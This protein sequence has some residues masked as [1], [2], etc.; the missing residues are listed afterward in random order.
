MSGVCVSDV[1]MSY[2]PLVSKQQVGLKFQVLSFKIADEID[3]N[4]VNNF[5]GRLLRTRSLSNVVICCQE[6]EEFHFLTR[7]KMWQCRLTPKK[8]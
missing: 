6:V 4:A 7:F 2:L 3:E 1:C 8:I 5:Q